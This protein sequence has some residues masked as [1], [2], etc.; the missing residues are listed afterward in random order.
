MTKISIKYVMFTYEIY[1]FVE[2]AN[3]SNFDKIISFKK[4]YFFENKPGK[5][6]VMY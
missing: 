6:A 3:K 1:S 2:Y 4:I 5:R